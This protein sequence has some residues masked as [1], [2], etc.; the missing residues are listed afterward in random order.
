MALCP[1]FSP[2]PV[3]QSKNQWW[4]LPLDGCQGPEGSMSSCI[5]YALFVLLTLASVFRGFTCHVFREEGDKL[6]GPSI[7]PGCHLYFAV[8]VSRWRSRQSANLPSSSIQSHFC[9]PGSLPDYRTHSMTSVC[10][11]AGMYPA[12]WPG[13]LVWLLQG[14]WQGPSPKPGSLLC[15]AAPERGKSILGSATLSLCKWFKWWM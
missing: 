12:S 15:R 11:L 6:N 13:P 14:M 3:Q 2:Y 9:K 8:A 10:S 1:N 5:L 7:V 4:T